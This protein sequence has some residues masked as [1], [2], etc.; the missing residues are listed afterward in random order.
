MCFYRALDRD[1]P[2]RFP[3]MI[4]VLGEAFPQVAVA[5]RQIGIA[6]P[7][8][9]IGA[10]LGKYENEPDAIVRQIQASPHYNLGGQ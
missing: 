1:R 7:E 3:P 10:D 9:R 4:E 8:A 5:C 6:E 2:R